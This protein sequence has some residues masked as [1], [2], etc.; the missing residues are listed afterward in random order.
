MSHGVTEDAAHRVAA[1]SHAV[2]E[3]AARVPQRCPGQSVPSAAGGS[4]WGAAGLGGMWHGADTDQR[5]R[6]EM[7]RLTQARTAER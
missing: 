1:V 6:A 7:G 2:P 5:H 3:D 4:G